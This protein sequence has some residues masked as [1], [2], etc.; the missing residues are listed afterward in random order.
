MTSLSTTWRK[1]PVAAPR[2]TLF[3]SVSPALSQAS[4]TLLTSPITFTTS[5][6]PSLF[7]SAIGT[8]GAVITFF[9]SAAMSEFL[10]SDSSGSAAAE[11]SGPRGLRGVGFSCGEHAASSF[12]VALFSCAWPRI[13]GNA[14]I[15]T[16]GK[17]KP[18]AAVS[19]SGSTE[20]ARRPDG[21]SPPSCLAKMLRRRFSSVLLWSRIRRMNSRKSRSPL[22][23]TSTWAMSMCRSPM[24]TV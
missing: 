12:K 7:I 6:L 18:I 17:P 10:L 23:S 4:L 3:L 2:A 22:R 20:A 19:A 14:W 8:S 1:E 21:A 15:S 16:G 13:S 24:V 9:W 5:P 11:L